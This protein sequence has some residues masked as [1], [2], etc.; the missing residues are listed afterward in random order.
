MIFCFWYTINSGN[1]RKVYLIYRK[2]KNMSNKL[3]LKMFLDGYANVAKKA[4]KLGHEDLDGRKTELNDQI[5]FAEKKISEMKNMGHKEFEQKSKIYMEIIKNGEKE[6]QDIDKEKDERKILKKDQEIKDMYQ[7]KSNI[8][9]NAQ[10]AYNKAKSEN[11]NEIE[12][13]KKELDDKKAEKAQRENEL[14]E[15]L[16]LEKKDP[17]RAKDSHYKEFLNK[18][19]EALNTEIKALEPSVKKQI[20][21]KEKEKQEINA[22]YR[23]FLLN[24]GKIDRNEE[25]I[26]MAADI[27][28]QDEAEKQKAEQSKYNKAWNDAIEENKRRDAAR[29]TS[30]QSTRGNA[31]GEEFNDNKL[32]EDIEINLGRKGTIIYDGEK[33]KIP[34]RALKEIGDLDMDD[35]IES[36]EKTGMKIEDREVLKKALNSKAIDYA[37][38]KGVC[39][40]KKLINES[41]S[42]ILN[43][44]FKDCLKASEYKDVENSCNIIYDLDDLSKAGGMDEFDKYDFI[45]RA[46]KAERFNVG[47][48]MGEFKPTFLSK[49]V[50]KIKG[51]N[52]KK[53]A[54]KNESV[55]IENASAVNVALDKKDDEAKD[56]IKGLRVDEKTNLGKNLENTE[57]DE[58]Q[59]SEI[60]NVYAH[61]KNDQMRT[62]N[63]GEER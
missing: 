11:E 31:I 23:R 13:I 36:I 3:D 25:L 44:Y 27:R 1:M 35:I 5:K 48:Q 57:L 18:K 21:Q 17:S 24:V 15:M 19:I 38:V 45:Q 46:K 50:A 20:V 12:N 34:R 58:S 22:E 53:L 29:T 59:L 16:D 41:K 32:P 2:E 8:I 10:D 56:F 39:S 61:Q 43:K 40:A 4:E 26:P 28:K 14:K 6:I 30:G 7:A 55:E 47:M 54:E 9:E 49:I 42:T 63:S 62:S 60:K 52:I 33:Y 37:V 51:I